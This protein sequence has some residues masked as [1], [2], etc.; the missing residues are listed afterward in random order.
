MNKRFWHTTKIF[1]DFDRGIQDELV[2]TFLTHDLREKQKRAERKITIS[3]YNKKRNLGA[4]AW[5]EK[6]FK[7]YLSFNDFCEICDTY[8]EIS[9]EIDS[10]KVQM[11]YLTRSKKVVKVSFG[12]V[13]IAFLLFFLALQQWFSFSKELYLAG[14]MLA[15]IAVVA[16]FISSIVALGQI[17]K[18]EK[19]INPAFNRL[20]EYTSVLN[21]RMKE[22]HLRFH[23]DIQLM[24]LDIVKM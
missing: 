20:V 22:K 24:Q 4:G 1:K 11:K 23:F 13:A 7:S 21:E 5:N 3:F 14:M 19:C 15:S 2:N 18:I 10:H 6:F 9:A 8:S 16:S 12:L 17:P